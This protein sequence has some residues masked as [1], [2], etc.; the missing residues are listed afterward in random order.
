ML[1]MD[2]EAPSPGT[3]HLVVDGEQ[4]LL[5]ESHAGAARIDLIQESFLRVTGRPLLSRG[6]NLWSTPQVV[7]AHG[8]E[9][10]PIFFYANRM[11]LALF[12]MPAGE[13]V[14]MPSRFSAEPME[15]DERARFLDA[16]S[17]QNYIAD[18]S[19]VRISRCGSRFRIARATVWNLLDAHGAIH[20]QAACFGTWE[21]LE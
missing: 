12:E 2:D 5:I 18:Y 8:S 16:V 6:E 13:I 7:L 19:G 11:A 14:R 9:A 15:R 20:G 10:D 4:Q 1:F 3:A 17:A 21:P